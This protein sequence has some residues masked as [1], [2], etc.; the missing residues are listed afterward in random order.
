MTPRSTCNTYITSSKWG[1][2][3]YDKTGWNDEIQYNCS[4]T[5]HQHVILTNN[6]HKHEMSPMAKHRSY[7]R[8]PMKC[9]ASLIL[10]SILYPQTQF[11]TCRALKMIL[12]DNRGHSPFESI[13]NKSHPV[14]FEV[15]CFTT[16]APSDNQE[17][18]PFTSNYICMTVFVQMTT[19]FYTIR[20]I[21]IFTL[22]P[23]DDVVATTYATRTARFPTSGLPFGKFCLST[24]HFLHQ[25]TTQKDIT[26]MGISQGRH[27]LIIGAALSCHR[28]GHSTCCI[29]RILWWMAGLLCDAGLLCV[30]GMLCVAGLLCIANGKKIM[31][32]SQ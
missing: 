13:A 16:F 1:N 31:K 21:W 14:D 27:T 3:H 26:K 28:L 10:V 15:C 7:G 17:R 20:C 32:I 6:E 9:I 4:F 29:S 11:F 22:H 5:W 30:P 23:K 18:F 19:P 25:F 8:I 12:S 24:E 2:K